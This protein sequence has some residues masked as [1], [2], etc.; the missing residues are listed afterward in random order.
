MSA[1]RSRVGLVVT[2]AFMLLINSLSQAKGPGFSKTNAELS[3]L[4]PTYLT[5][6]G[7]TFAIWPIIYLLEGI[8]TYQEVKIQGPISESTLRRRGCL[9]LAFVLNAF[10]LFLFTNELYVLSCA[11]I[12]AYLAALAF[13][14]KDLDFTPHKGSPFALKAGVAVNLTWLC[15]ATCINMLIAR[16]RRNAA[17]PLGVALSAPAGSQAGATVIAVALTA[18][19]IAAVRTRYDAG[20]AT[21]ASWALWGVQRQQ[22]QAGASLIASIAWACALICAVA[23]ARGIFLYKRAKT[24]D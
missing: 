20:V 9:S 23:A 7:A 22:S 10:W 17:M 3:D 18:L 4:S 8:A 21:A 16:A 14:Y 12:I 11:V 13:V 19:A 15:V 6:D 1:A 2:F 5:P 24:E